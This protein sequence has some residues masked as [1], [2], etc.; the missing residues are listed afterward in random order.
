MNRAVKFA[1]L[2]TLEVIVLITFGRVSRAANPGSESQSMPFAC[3]IETSSAYW[4]KRDGARLTVTITNKSEQAANVRAL[5]SVRLI[6]VPSSAG[7]PVREFWAPLDIAQ[8]RATNDWHDLK[9]AKGETIRRKVSALD[10]LWSPVESSV[11]PEKPFAE[12][13]PNGQYRLRVQV[14]LKEQHQP[15]TS[16]DVVI[17]VSD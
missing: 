15:V 3:R 2:I 17:S 5:L 11:W 9:L 14:E 16:N 7:E 12:T 10:L 1:L 13:I 6:S 4:S 8:S